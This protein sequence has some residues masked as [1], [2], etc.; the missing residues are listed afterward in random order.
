MTQLLS[1]KIYH[2]D[3]QALSTSRY[4]WLGKIV[5]QQHSGRGD[6]F[7]GNKDD[8]VIRTI[9]FMLQ[10]KHCQNMLLVLIW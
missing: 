1:Y 3:L 2:L 10:S 8:V 9:T 6:F 4:D 5:N 7:L